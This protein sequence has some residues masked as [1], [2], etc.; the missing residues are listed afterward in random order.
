ED[1][2]RELTQVPF[3]PQT[4]HQCGP[5]A[6]ATVLGASGVAATPAQLAPLV[7]IPGRR[8]SLQVEMLA[9]ARTRG[10]VAYVLEPGFGRIQ[11][12][13]AGGTPVL[14]LQ[15]LGAFGIR[16]WHFAVVVGYD[17]ERDVVVLRSGTRRRHLERRSDFLRTWQGGDE[18]AAVVTRPDQPP[19]TATGGAFIRALAATGRNLPPEALQAGHAA[20]LE[21][22][23]GDPLVLLASGNDAYASRRFA[24]AIAL[25]GELLIREPGNI[26]G[27]NN[28]ANALLDAGCPQSALDEASTAAAQ[29]AP[30]TPLEAAVR[31][32]LASAT[33]AAA[34]AARPEGPGPRPGT[35]PPPAAAPAQSPRC[36]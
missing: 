21:R 30:G 26:A 12:E 33:A 22:W 14:V 34:G 6:L 16:R 29:V 32:T 2:A 5:A 8:G 20:A 4:I 25:Y 9:A 35:T 23:P 19:V 1:P 17:A 10:R 13:L 24:D 7:Y 15:D 27:R 18:W 11:A 31:D 28:L 3:F 36:P